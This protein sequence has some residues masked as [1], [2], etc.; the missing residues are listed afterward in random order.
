[1]ASWWGH[2]LVIFSL[3][4]CFTLWLTP[5]VRRVALR[6]GVVD[7]PNHRKVHRSAV[8]RLGG[9]AVFLG[10]AAAL[11][12]SGGA[13]ALSAETDA[14]IPLAVMGTSVLVVLF[15]LWD[16]CV[17][18][19]GRLKLVLQ[20]A[21]ASV[22]F[23]AG[24]RIDRITNPFGGELLFPGPLTYAVTVLWIIGMMNAVNLIDGLDGLACGI[25]GI[26]ALG[27]LAAG[28]YLD[29][30]T[31]VV[32]LTA[33]AGACAGFLRYN[34][35]PA[36]IFLGDAGSQFLGF[37]FAVTALIDNQYKSATAVALLIPLTALSVPIA[38]TALAFLRR[39]RRRRSIF[40]ADKGHL[41]HR[42]LALGLA[43]REVVLFFYL[44]SAYL[45]LLSFLFVLINDRY[46]LVL[47]MLLALGLFM[48]MQTL[49]FVEFKVLRLARARLS[50]R[51]A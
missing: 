22:V 41:H 49:R 37:V 42:L 28:F 51:P 36:T 33:L 39:V 15:G 25:A 30:P 26:T 9:V 1:M 18:L 43:H 12:V 50:R 48:A 21:V 13:G 11:M 35:Y 19:S 44:T 24:L 46:A 32:I 17:N 4:A 10:W 47:L 29:S 45:S 38:D 20:V 16:D 40:R 6:L 5:L 34:F 7:Q 27:L 14:G 23:W 31:S 3:A 2:L 8:P